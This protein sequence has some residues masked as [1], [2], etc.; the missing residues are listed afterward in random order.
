LSLS[1][2]IQVSFLY[3]IFGQK[4]IV[5]KLLGSWSFHGFNFQYFGNKLFGLF[6]EVQFV[7]ILIETVLAILDALS[8]L[9]GIIGLKRRLPKQQ[10]ISILIE[11]YVR[12]PTAHT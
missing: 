6:G 8:G 1:A 10:S 5:Q 4:G 3:V 11:K 2:E 9:L 12:T 7:P